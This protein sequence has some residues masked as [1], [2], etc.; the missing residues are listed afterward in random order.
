MK[1]LKDFRIDLEKLDSIY[2]QEAQ[3]LKAIH[4]SNAEPKEMLGLAHAA[5]MVKSNI[6]KDMKEAG[7]DDELAQTLLH[8]FDNRVGLYYDKAYAR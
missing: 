8:V 2:F 3:Q 5:A 1:T 7:F 6:M 4:A